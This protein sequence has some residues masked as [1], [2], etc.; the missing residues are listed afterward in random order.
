VR[1]AFS[2]FNAKDRLDVMR[3]SAMS[4]SY[5][6]SLSAARYNGLY[7]KTIGATAT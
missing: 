5:S 1:R 4:Q 2:T 3:R 6:W 7:R